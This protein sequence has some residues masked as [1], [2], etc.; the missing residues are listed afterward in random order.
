MGTSG[1]LLVLGQHGER[2]VADLPAVA[3]RA[4]EDG[5]APQRREP[6]DVRRAVLHPGG[7]EDRAGTLG[8][9][10]RELERE[11][12]AG[13]GDGVAAQLDGVVGLQLLAAGA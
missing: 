11:A 13:G 6:G 12:L 2:L 9:A 7:E 1:G 10:A 8:R 3:E 4:V 5:V